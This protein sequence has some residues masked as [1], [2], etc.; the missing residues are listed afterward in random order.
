LQAELK[1]VLEEASHPVVSGAVE[2]ARRIQANLRKKG[3]AFTDSGRL[4]A[5]D[6]RR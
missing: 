2:T 5:Q 4:Q 6:R 3:I 1:T